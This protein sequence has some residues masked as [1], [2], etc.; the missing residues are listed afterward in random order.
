MLKGLW[1]DCLFSNNSD[2]AIKCDWLYN[3]CFFPFW[4]CEK[5]LDCNSKCDR[6]LRVILTMIGFKVSLALVYILH[7][8]LEIQNLP[9]LKIYVWVGFW[10][11]W[12]KSTIDLPKILALFLRRILGAYMWIIF[13][14]EFNGIVV[15]VFLALRFLGSKTRGKNLHIASTYWSGLSLMR[16]QGI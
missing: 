1:K 6:V 11:F 15:D 10:L 7:S 13:L 4:R 3:A 12:I 9:R 5:G 8:I 16:S 14:R 2:S